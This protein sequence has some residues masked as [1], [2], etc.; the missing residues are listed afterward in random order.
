MSGG[1]DQL[2]QL[3]GVILDRELATVRERALHVAGLQARIGEIERALAAR[4]DALAQGP[5]TEDL[6]GLTG[7]DAIWQDWVRRERIRLQAELARVMAELEER[8][9]AARRAFGRAEAMR[10]LKAAEASRRRQQAIRRAAA[11]G[12]PA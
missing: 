4:G 5:A 12:D 2:A 11:R 6:A 10:D 8:R 1:F 7:R 3:T 9:L